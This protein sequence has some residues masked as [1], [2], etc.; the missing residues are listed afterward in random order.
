MFYLESAKYYEYF[1]SLFMSV[2]DLY[3][4]SYIKGENILD[5]INKNK[6][7]GRLCFFDNEAGVVLKKDASI[8]E[9]SDAISF[10]Y[11]LFEE[12][13]LNIT[14][15]LNNEEIINYLDILDIDYEIKDVNGYQVVLENGNVL[16]NGDI[17]NDLLVFKMNVLDVVNEVI[18]NNSN[19]ISLNNTSVYVI[20]SSQEEKMRAL[21]LVQDLRWSEIK[22]S[23]DYA[24]KSRDE[25]LSDADSLN[26]RLIVILKDEDL[27][28][29]IITVRDNLTKEE[30]KIDESEIIDYIISNL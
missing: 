17:L 12:M 25:Q 14:V 4:F 13:G 20:A 21:G 8:L 5:Y 9:I 23:I 22:T 16:V 30:E 15:Y 3:N 26:A 29:G 6:I 28:K 2:A 24:N 18:N 7:C 11:R 1:N 19:S 27:Q 10:I